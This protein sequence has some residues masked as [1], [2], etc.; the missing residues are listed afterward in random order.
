M[1]SPELAN[2]DS[3]CQGQTG[4]TIL[5]ACLLGVAFLGLAG[6]VVHF[7][8]AHSPDDHLWHGN[9][10]DPQGSI[11]GFVWFISAL[12]ATIM[13]RSLRPPARELILVGGGVLTVLSIIFWFCVAVSM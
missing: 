4:Q 10:P 3:K 7:A 13:S 8:K 9:D 11:L 6:F 12:F 2:G 5:A 1:S